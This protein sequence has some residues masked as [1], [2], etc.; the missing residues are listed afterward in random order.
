MKIFGILRLIFSLLK[1]TITTVEFATIPTDAITLC[2]ITIICDVNSPSSIAELFPML[3]QLTKSS[4]PVQFWLVLLSI[5]NLLI[6]HN[7]LWVFEKLTI[8]VLLFFS[9]ENVSP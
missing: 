4:R 5:Q 9:D 3:L 8:D 2:R 1:K 6:L 7:Q